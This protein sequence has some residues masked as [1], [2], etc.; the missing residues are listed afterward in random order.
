MSPRWVSGFGLLVFILIAWVLSEERR[1]FPW[2]AV[3]WGLV[4][5]FGFALLILKTAPGRWVFFGF[6]NAVTRFIGFAN[7]GNAMM[8]G[9]LANQSLLA[10]KLGPAN[11]LIL[12]ITVTGTIILVAT[13]SSV[14]YHWGILQRVVRA[15]AWVM[16]RAMGTS[17]GETLSAAANIFMGQTE[18]PLLIKPYLPG[19]TRSELLAVMIGGMA[20]IAGGVLAAY[21]G[22]GIEAGHLLTASVLS[23]P[24]G[25]LISKILVP[26]SA[27]SQTAAGAPVD[28][29]R[30]TVN[31][32][33]ALVRGASDGMTLSINVA[34]MIIAMVSVVACVNW[35][36]SSAGGWC[37]ISDPHPLQT[38]LGW[39]NAPFAWLMGVQFK[40]CRAVGAMLGERIVLNEFVAYLSLV[41]TQ[42]SLEPRSVVIAT[43][44]LCGFANIGS[45]AIQI[46]GIGALAPTRRA[47]LARF[48]LRALIGG[49]LACYLTAAVVGLLL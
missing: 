26:E 29:P 45:I 6:Q 34:A 11:G 20:T 16:Q 30:E 44:A 27:R 8:F 33:D 3:L 36:L 17:G 21:V 13:V 39:A 1:R 43:Y 15:L 46:G 24:A 40:D 2:R 37:G 19:M 18:A 38:L 47:D 31:M 25:L 14:L 28:V 23:A 42:S 10:E 32:I 41:R 5:Q 49:L 4:L 9:P 12:V 48:G 7:E 22:F 35:M